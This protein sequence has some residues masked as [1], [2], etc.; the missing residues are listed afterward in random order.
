MKH[1]V[2]LEWSGADGRLTEMSGYSWRKPLSSSGFIEVA[3]AAAAYDGDGGD[4]ILIT[5]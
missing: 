4:V 3:A 1:E 2:L 5:P